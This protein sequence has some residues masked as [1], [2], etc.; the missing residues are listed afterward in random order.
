[1]IC[2]LIEARINQQPPLRG[3]N[4]PHRSQQFRA[5][6]LNWKQAAFR[7]RTGWT[8]EIEIVP[9][10]RKPAIVIGTAFARKIR[11]IAVWAEPI[12]L[13]GAGYADLAFTISTL[14]FE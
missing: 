2:R 3:P 8:S 13:A 6:T 4:L 5:R 14:V 10:G 1:M 9:I 12:N 7:A 11:S